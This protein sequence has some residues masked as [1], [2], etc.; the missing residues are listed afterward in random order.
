MYKR[1]LAYICKPKSNTPIHLNKT[2]DYSRVI[3]DHGYTPVASDTLFG[4]F[5]DNNS[6][7]EKNEVVK[8]NR[9]L[10]R[11]SFIMFVCGN[12]ITDKMKQE[13]LYARQVGVTVVPLDG[14]TQITEYLKKGE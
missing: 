4:S 6:I 3:F 1:P 7:E 14:I 11:K 13:M 5:I 12:Y 10:I 2:L 8:M 9:V